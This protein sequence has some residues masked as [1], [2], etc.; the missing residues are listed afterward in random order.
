MLLV[1]S[2]GMAASAWVLNCLLDDNAKQE[3]LRGAGLMMEST[4]SVRGDS[5]N[6]VKP[7]L[8][9]Q[10]AETFL[11]QTVPA[12]AATEIFGVLHA[13][14]PD[15]RYDE[16][17][18][19]PTNPRDRAVDWGS[20][21]IQKVRAAPATTDLSGERPAATGR[22]LCVARPIAIKD[23]A[24]LQC[25]SVP[26]A[27]PASKARI[28]G[29]DSGFGWQHMETVDA[30]VKSVPL[31]GPLANAQRT[32]Q[33]FVLSLDGI[34]LAAFVVL[35]LRLSWLIIGPISRM[36]GVAARASTGDFDVTDV[37]REPR[38]NRCASGVVQPH[39]A[40]PVQGHQAGRRLM[41]NG[42]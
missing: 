22:M 14:Y 36:A 18:L 10:L 9:P 30:Q 4:L 25:H 13:K 20:D 15:F 26:A 40:Q 21:L 35:N 7:L 33:A 39:A 28:Y 23:G 34:S 32:F 1:F 5:V 12:R 41:R 16:A 37:P 2:V 17:T 24:G 29:P 11:P 8:E 42:T 38:R 19:N 31:P 3:T 27:A 6:Q